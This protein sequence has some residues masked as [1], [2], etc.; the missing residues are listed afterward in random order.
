MTDD[1]DE[2]AALLGERPRRVPR[3]PR[4]PDPK[5]E[6]QRKLDVAATGKGEVQAI[7]FLRPVTQNLL[8]EVFR[9]QPDTVKRR[10]LQ[11]PTIGTGKGR[12]LYDFKT[13]CEY[14][15]KP[16]MDLDTYIKSLN[17][18]DL[19]PIISKTYWEAQRIKNKVLLET[20][21]A[22]STP[23]VLEVFGVVFMLIKDRIPLITE[24]MRDQ[25]LTD[26]QLEHLE[27]NVDH[28]QTD[29]HEALIELPAQRQTPSRR[30]EMDQLI[31][32]LTTNP[33]EDD[34]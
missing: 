17:Q 34:E 25:G 29:L 7:D 24:E 12:I 23:E 32:D 21:E 27:A 28:F 11:C 18:A 5:I 2:F 26:A 31:T 19:P 6:F 13:A 3:A 30:A 33:N 1:T 14:L 10:L 4:L 20:A 22:W 16:R 15:L 9:M 8:S